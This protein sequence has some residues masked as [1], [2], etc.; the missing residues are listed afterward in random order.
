M[1]SRRRNIRYSLP[2]L[3]LLLCLLPVA[4]ADS[5][6]EAE[7]EHEPEDHHASMSSGADITEPADVHYTLR[8]TFGA[9]GIGYIGVGGDIDGILN[10]DLTA[11]EGNIVA[12]TIIN[13]SG[14]E[15]DIMFP[16][17]GAM[18]DHIFSEGETS[19]VKFHADEAGTFEYYCGVTGH[20]AAGMQGK[21]IVTHAHDMETDDHH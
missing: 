16:D 11:S 3:F 2:V 4:L 20:R 1:L 21:F 12:V 5:T 8:A 7:H 9:D 10:P 17:F 6:H 15:H 18:A 14:L 19:T 13:A